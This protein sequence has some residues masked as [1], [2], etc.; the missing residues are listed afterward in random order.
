MAIMMA[1]GGGGCIRASGLIYARVEGESRSE[2]KG[3]GR[4]RVRVRGRVVYQ[5]EGI[6]WRR[7]LAR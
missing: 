2:P 5:A 1:V 7:D 4:V 6:C 3:G